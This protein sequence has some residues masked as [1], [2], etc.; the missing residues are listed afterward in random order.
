MTNIDY[1]KNFEESLK[2]VK[3]NLMITSPREKLKYSRDF[4]D[5]SPVLKEKLD[6]CLAEFVVRPQTVNAVS[7]IASLC[8]QYNQ[9]L[10]IRGSGTGNYGQCVPLKGGV[11]MIMSDINTIRNIDSSTGIVTVE[12]GCL[13]KDLSKELS[14]NERQLRLMPSTWRSA[15]IGGFVSG[16]SGGI[17]SIKYGFLRDPGHLLGMEVVTIENNSR[18]IQL[19]EN[20]SEPLN[21]AY[22]TN[23]IITSLTISTAPLI[24]WQEVIIDFSDWLEAVNMVKTLNSSAIELFLCTLLEKNIVEKLPNWYRR[25]SDVHRIILLAS[26]DSIST[27]KRLNSE[28]SSTVYH[29]GSEDESSGKGVKE[30]T[31][32]HTTLHMRKTDPNWTYLQMLLPEEEIP[33]LEKIKNVWGNNIFWHIESVKQN[34]KQRM[35]ALPV[36]YWKNEVLLNKLINDCRENGAIIFN[37]HVITVEDGGLGVIDADQVDAKRFY[38]PMG[39]LNP[40]KLK[41][42][43]Q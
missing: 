3:N 18:I 1:H 14:R 4:Y 9:P 33:F 17:G 39:L 15:S 19:D 34:G 30:L 37:P 16:G 32:N 38:D 25:P 6:N 23:G 10:T 21:H 29:I 35:A 12:S 8:C 13:L 7:E 41:G 2:T 26:P 43:P 5:Y 27:I 42:W 24:E 36:V 22:G 28:S 20:R 11:V 31:W 40:G